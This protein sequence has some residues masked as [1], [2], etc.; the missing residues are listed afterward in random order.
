MKIVEKELEVALEVLDD[1]RLLLKEK[2]FRSAVNRA[3]YAIMHSAKAL[4][5][6]LGIETTSHPGIIRMFGQEVVKKNL[7]D[8]KY[9]K[10]LSGAY[11]LRDKSDYKIMELIKDEKVAEAVKEAE[12]F[13]AEIQR[14]IEKI[15]K[16][17]ELN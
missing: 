5:T 2:R 14:V 3:Y 10:S 15:T 1:A 13:V 16:M 12:D 6:L 17:K 9:A 8:K 7:I 4:L 11:N